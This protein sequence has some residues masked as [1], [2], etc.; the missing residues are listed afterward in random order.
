M[1]V[2]KETS[3]RCLQDFEGEPACLKTKRRLGTRAVACK[4]GSLQL[5][6]LSRSLLLAVLLQLREALDLVKPKAPGMRRSDEKPKMESEDM[7]G[8]KG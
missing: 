2:R 8:S 3:Q 1:D 6:R 7:V 4:T 5:S